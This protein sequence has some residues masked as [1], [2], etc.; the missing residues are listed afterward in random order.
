M[1]SYKTPCLA[2]GTSSDVGIQT[3]KNRGQL[4][5]TPPGGAKGNVLQML[6]PWA[7]TSSDSSL[8]E[9]HQNELQVDFFGGF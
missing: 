5:T 9:F 6:A 4:G 1:V 8:Y 2:F 3:G 7:L